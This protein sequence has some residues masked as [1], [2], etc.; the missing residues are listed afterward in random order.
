MHAKTIIS[1]CKSNDEQM[2]FFK[3]RKDIMPLRSF[4][5]FVKLERGKEI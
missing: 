4:F 5:Y 1:I 2:D 3:L